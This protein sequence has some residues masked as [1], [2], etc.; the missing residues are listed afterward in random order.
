MARD[1]GLIVHPEDFDYFLKDA[2]TEEAG[3]LIRNMIRAFQGDFEGIKNFDDRFMKVT[4]EKICGRILRE[5][6][7]SIKRSYAGALGGAPVGNQNNKSS[8]SQAKVKQ[9]T[10]KSQ[11]QYNQ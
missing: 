8:K 1:Y 4:S 2:T 7:L 10:S 6:E 9:S 11:T 5:R 3:E